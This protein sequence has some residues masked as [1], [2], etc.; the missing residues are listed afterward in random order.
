MSRVRN[1]ISKYLSNQGQI[2]VHFDVNSKDVDGFKMLEAELEESINMEEYEDDFNISG[3]YAVSGKTILL[4]NEDGQ[5]V[6]TINDDG[7]LSMIVPL[8]G[9]NVEVIMTKQK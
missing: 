1:F 6:V 4:A 5:D 2:S 9:E 7:T 8:D 3:T